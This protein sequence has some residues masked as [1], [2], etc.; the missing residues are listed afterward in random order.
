MMSKLQMYGAKLT[1]SVQIDNDRCTFL[2]S[3]RA[4]NVA[5]KSFGGYTCSND[6]TK[7]I[8]A[9]AMMATNIIDVRIY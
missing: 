3:S 5:F 4:A 7:P 9:N 2:T 6:D 8:Q 1:G